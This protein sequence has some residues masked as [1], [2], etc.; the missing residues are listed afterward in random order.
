MPITVSFGVFGFPGLT[1][2]VEG[3]SF[4]PRR[5][6]KTDPAGPFLI[7]ARDCGLALDTG[8]DNR[9]RARPL[10]WPPHADRHQL[11]FLQPSGVAG[12]AL[13]VSAANGHALDATTNSEQSELVMWEPNAEPWQ[14][15]KLNKSPDGA[16]F[17]IQ[18]M[19]NRRFL[20]VSGDAEPR[21][22]PWFE[23]RLF[24]WSQQWIFALPHG[25]DPTKD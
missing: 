6:K 8:L 24:N 5:K 12:E 3:V 25:G 14:R 21:W 22:H 11:W 4:T 13:I 15:W 17:E 23:D 20:T 7:I 2:G 19:H 16:A 18:S 10:L 9:P 1:V